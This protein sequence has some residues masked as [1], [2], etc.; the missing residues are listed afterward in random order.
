MP[1]EPAAVSL[2]APDIAARV[3]WLLTMSAAREPEAE[4]ESGRR[5]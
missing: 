1:R 4:S 5:I 3:I 2:P